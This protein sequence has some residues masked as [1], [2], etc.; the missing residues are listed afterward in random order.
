MFMR[1]ELNMLVIASF[2]LIFLSA[3]LL[4]ALLPSY[5][6][7]QKFFHGQKPKENTIYL[8]FDDGPSEF[9]KDLL[10]LLKQ[11]NIKATFFCVATFA[12]EHKNIIQK[13][14]QDGH[15]IALHSLKHKNAMLQGISETKN[16]LEQSLAIMQELGVSIQYYRP[17]W[18][19]T[20]LALL[21]ELKKKNLPCILWDVMAED[22]EAT[23][24]EE[25]IANKLLER[26]KP[27][28]IICLHDGRG[29][30]DAPQKTIFALKKAIPLFLEKGFEFKTID[31]YKI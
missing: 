17:P 21:K 24:S 8:T 12:K 2:V 30:N 14:Q 4:Y 3:F 29:K 18:G 16:D 28:D 31:E 13:M 1:K 23:T 11:Y 20:N 7:K 19:D 26:T 6:N 5:W 25:I 9:T 15:L 22:W 27:G 10:S